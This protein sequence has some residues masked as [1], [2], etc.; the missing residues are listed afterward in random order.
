MGTTIM[1][2]T[3]VAIV[4]ALLIAIECALERITKKQLPKKKRKTMLNGT[5]PAWDEKR[6]KFIIYK[7]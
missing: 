1:I 7:N 5:Y 2:L 6:G 4:L 3:G